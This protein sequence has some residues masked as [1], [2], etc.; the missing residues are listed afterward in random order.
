MFDGVHDQIWKLYNWS[1][2]HYLYEC[3]LL[4]RSKKRLIPTP[5]FLLFYTNVLVLNP[6]IFFLD[7]SILPQ[8]QP[9]RF[10]VQG[11]I[12]QSR[13]V[14]SSEPEAKMFWRSCRTEKMEPQPSSWKKFLD[15]SQDPSEKSWN[16]REKSWTSVKISWDI[17]S[18]I[19]EI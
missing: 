2:N 6:S 7:P 10:S 18:N 14:L 9:P 17:M 12:S 1:W 11:A 15:F 4:A 19:W 8:G 3:L 16:L 13:T 5:I